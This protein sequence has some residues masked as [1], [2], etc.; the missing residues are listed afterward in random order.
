VCGISGKK[1]YDPDGNPI[2]W[3]GNMRPKPEIE[4]NIKDVTAKLV[5][6]KYEEE[7]TSVICIG[8]RAAAMT[9]SYEQHPISCSF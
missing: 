3:K 8:R 2:K 9:H 7:D 6:A 5:T 1:Y 4:A